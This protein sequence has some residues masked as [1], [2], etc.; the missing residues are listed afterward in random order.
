MADEQ[1]STVPFL[2]LGNKIDAKDAV[3]EQQLKDALGIFNTT[4]KK[5]TKSKL[6]EGQQPIEIYMC[7]VVKRSGY[8]EG[9][10]WLSEFL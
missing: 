10:K 6:Q 8:G 7:S 1:L 4:G 5:A 2:I 9:F 3:S